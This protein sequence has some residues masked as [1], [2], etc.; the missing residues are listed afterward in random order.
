MTVL[1]VFGFMMLVAVTL[2][3]SVNDKIQSMDIFGADSKNA[4][5][6]VTE[7]YT[8]AVDNGFGLLAIGLAIVALILA[9]LV[10]VHPIFIPLFIIIWVI[11]IFVSGIMS[12]I[13]D[14]AATN[15]ALSAQ[16][17]QLNTISLLLT[18]LPW[19]IGVFGMILMVVMYKLWSNAQQ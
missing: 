7:K 9:S 11:I 14:E 5:N 3:V 10:R 15:P 6:T 16:A 13:Y 19:F 2:N 1:T 8:S 4:A 12:N 18:K 17:D